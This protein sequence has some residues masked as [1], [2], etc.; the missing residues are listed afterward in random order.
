L[1]VSADLGSV[2]QLEGLE[3]EGEAGK[4]EALNPVGNTANAL[5][6][7]TKTGAVSADSRKNLLADSL[8]TGEDELI[9]FRRA[10][11]RLAEMQS[12]QY[13]AAR[14]RGTAVGE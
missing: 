5:G 14:S 8:F 3:F 11:S 7:A 4:A 10:L 9:A 12:A 13:Y 1:C 2:L 6:S